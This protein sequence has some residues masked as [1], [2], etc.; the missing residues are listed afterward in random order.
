MCGSG[1]RLSTGVGGW[2]VEGSLVFSVVKVE[3]G[4]I[5][6]D[7]VFLSSIVSKISASV[8]QLIPTEFEESMKLTNGKLESNDCKLDELLLACKNSG[9]WSSSNVKVIQRGLILFCKKH[10]K[11]STFQK[12]SRLY[13][14]YT[15]FK[16]FA[17]I[18]LIIQTKW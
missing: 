8:R 11:I 13:S 14:F 2:N 16:V 3:L 18:Y 12:R 6:E 4:G 15:L 9:V 10:K 1:I 17:S 5:I 7:A